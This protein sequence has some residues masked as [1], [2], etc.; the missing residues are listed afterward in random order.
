[1]NSINNLNNKKILNIPIRYI[2][3][4]L[5]LTQVAYLIMFN[6]EHTNLYSTI[7]YTSVCYFSLFIGYYL[8]WKIKSKYKNYHYSKLIGKVLIFSTIMTVVISMYNII[9]FYPDLSEISRFV[10]NPGKA[11]EYVKYLQRNEE[12]IPTNLWSSVIGITLNALTFTKYILAGF[13]VLYWKHI[14]KSS[15][16]LIIISLIIYIMQSFLIG[17]MINVG[18][19]FI[20][21]LPILILKTKEKNIIS[22]FKAKFIMILFASITFLVLLYFLGSRGL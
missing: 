9:A 10:F 8:N 12:A 1:M 7:I 5:F 4:Y 20:S 6:K 21:I 15:K 13:S 11:Y 17:A 14:K 2:I 3:I 16:L 18:A 19:L 22:T